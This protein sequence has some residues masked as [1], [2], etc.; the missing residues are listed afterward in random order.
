MKVVSREA[1][2]SS[3]IESIDCS[4]ASKRTTRSVRRARA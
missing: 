1:P 3:L 4:V 2:R